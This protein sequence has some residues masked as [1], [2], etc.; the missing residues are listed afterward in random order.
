MPNSEINTSNPFDLNREIV[1]ARSIEALGSISA[2]MLDTADFAIRSGVGTK[3]V[4]QLIS[5]FN[6]AITLRLISLL[7]STEG[8]HLPEGAT[9]LALGSEGRGEQTLRTDQ[10]SAIIYSDDFP[11][12]KLHIVKRFAVRLVNALEEIG[13]P[14]CPGNIMAD[15]PQWRHSLTEWKRLLNQWITA[16]TP[17]HMLN[18][19]IFQDLRPLHGN[20][21][22]GSELRDHIRTTVHN[23]ACFFPNM[24]YHAARFPPP[25]TLFGRIRVERRGDNRGKIDI[26][27]AG[28]FAI[29]VGVSLLA[30]ENGFIGGTTWDK[31]ELLGRGNIVRAGDLKTIEEAFTYLVQLRL[32]WQLREQSANRKPTN[33]VDPRVM[34]DRERDQFRHALKGVITFL[35]FFRTHYKLD[36][37][38]R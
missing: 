12:E 21:S 10:D 26:K 5:R 11:P 2:R 13:V 23:T 16:P 14:R 25:L 34:T 31:L 36:F 37:I 22:L 33:H 7:E 29:T 35:H 3:T 27:K 28:I 1:T 18:F 19:G 38:S 30:L 32:Q 9:Y 20:P 4:V 8:I 17:E 6:D 24:A 15:N